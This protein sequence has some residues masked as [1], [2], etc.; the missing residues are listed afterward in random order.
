MWGGSTLSPTTQL[1]L[2]IW[3]IYG[4]VL[5]YPF[6]LRRH[7]GWFADHVCWLHIRQRLHLAQRRFRKALSHSMAPGRW[8]QPDLLTHPSSNRALTRL[9]AVPLKLL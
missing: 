9:I 5:V 7:L 8:A 6:D 3:G 2:V 1:Q 4:D